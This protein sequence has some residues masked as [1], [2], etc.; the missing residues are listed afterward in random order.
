MFLFTTHRRALKQ[1]FVM[2]E[3][4]SE[5]TQGISEDMGRLCIEVPPMRGVDED[6]RRWSFFMVLEHNTIVNKLITATVCQL[7][8]GESLHGAAKIDIK[9]DVMPSP[10]AGN[11][12]LRA[13][14]ESVQEHIKAVNSLGRL[15][16]TKTTTHPI[17]GDFDSHKWN[18]MFSFHLS[19]HYSQ[20][21]Y[22]VRIAKAEQGNG[23]D[24]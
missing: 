7:A 23:G 18:C 17:F 8:K 3:K 15:R 2:A 10:S 12:Q 13:F 9:S 1:A 22:V 16:G 5:L 21:T 14:Q 6:M 4:Y 24:S 11:E 19:L 20:A